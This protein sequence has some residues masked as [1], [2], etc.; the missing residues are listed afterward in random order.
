MRT[1]VAIIIGMSVLAPAAW[2]DTPIYKWVDPQGVVHYS[3][4]PHSDDAKQLTI[5]NTGTLPGASTAAAPASATAADASLVVPTPADSPTCRAARDHL[6]QYLHSDLYKVD[7]K[8][9][10]QKL[11]AEDTQNALNDARNDVNQA[12]GPGGQ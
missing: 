3:T 11:S 6:Y 5:V 9:Q 10:K 4:E 7:D 1:L 12:C 8:G 2:G